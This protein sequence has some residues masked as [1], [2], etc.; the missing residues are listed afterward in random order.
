MDIEKLFATN[1]QVRIIKVFLENPTKIYSS[2]T[3]AKKLGSSPSAIIARLKVLEQLGIIKA[4]RLNRMRLYRL[5]LESKA[6]KILQE[7]YHKIKDIR[8]DK[9]E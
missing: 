9:K 6:T 5:N 7:F 1:L 8:G 4:I 3:I 2:T